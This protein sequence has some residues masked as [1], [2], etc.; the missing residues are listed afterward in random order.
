[1]KRALGL[2]QFASNEM[3]KMSFMLVFAR[4]W[5]PRL[6]AS[7]RL[8]FTEIRF[9]HILKLHRFQKVKVI[10][11]KLKAYTHTLTYTWNIITIVRA[12]FV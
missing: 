7:Y 1:M 9:T 10:R 3:N 2:E 8:I 12:A 4:P 6:S 5:P 11:S